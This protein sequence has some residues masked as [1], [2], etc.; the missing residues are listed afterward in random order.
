MKNLLSANDGSVA[1]TYEYG[2]FGELL[3]GDGAMATLNPFRFSTKFQDGE[4]E[5][6]Y[7][8]Y[9]YYNAGVG[10]WF[11]RD[12]IDEAGGLNSYDLI[13]NSPIN[14]FDLLGMKIMGCIDSYLSGSLKLKE[15]VDYS[16]SKDGIYSV[17]GDVK[18]TDAGDLSKV[19]VIRMMKASYTFNLAGGGESA[20][21]AN[22]R[23]HV[24]ARRTIVNNALAANFS[25]GTKGG[26]ATIPVNAGALLEDAQKYFDSINSK[27]PITD[28]NQGF[29]IAC[30]PLSTIIFA[31]GNGN[32]NPGHRNYDGVWIPGDW[33]YIRN[34]DYE[35]HPERWG[36]D[37]MA[38]GAWAGE[39]V[40]HTGISGQDE[41]FWG[42]FAPGKHPSIKEKEWF[43]DV[44]K[45]WA[46]KNG[47]KGHG[48]PKWRT[49]IDH[50]TV[51]LQ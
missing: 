22:L 4:T 25:F 36:R 44:S 1:A 13:A 7:Y 12:P 23:K 21:E 40:F 16:K 17:S 6:L 30:Q 50:T 32:N 11:S 3:R 10:R 49:R 28:K 39:N 48:V 18:G 15:G 42:H 51:G 26:S 27:D 31:T 5:L 37:G 33:A 29:F 8:G 20:N 46:D 45:V 41:M 24:T 38:P 47:E 34:V 19:I 2:P 35:E 14:A 9:R 43:E